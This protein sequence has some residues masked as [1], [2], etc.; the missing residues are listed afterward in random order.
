MSCGGF[1]LVWCTGIVTV[2][3]FI[4]HKL[5]HQQEMKEGDGV[6][7]KTV[8]G[9]VDVNRPMKCKMKSGVALLAWYWR[10]LGGPTSRTLCMRLNHMNLL[11]E[12]EK[13]TLDDRRAR[14]VIVVF[15]TVN[16]GMENDPRL[17]VRHFGR[18]EACD[19]CV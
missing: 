15:V 4:K 3:E 16:T 18:F 14:E 11:V 12:S 2:A 5:L 6:V 7:A 10:L 13:P 17:A 19:R 9:V 1:W 8:E